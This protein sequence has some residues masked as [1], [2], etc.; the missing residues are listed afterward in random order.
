MADLVE[1]REEIIQNVDVLHRY[2]LGDGPE[3]RFH[4]GR[5]KNG[6]VFAAVRQGDEYRFAPSKFAGYAANNLGHEQKL[7]ERDC[8]VTNQRI[9]SIAGPPLEIGSAAYRAVDDAYLAYCNT[10]GINTP[11]C[12]ASSFLFWLCHNVSDT[13]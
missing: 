11:L 6:K 4:D 8:G 7:A 2:G 5:I 13:P 3:R 10:H 12:L 9:E 1:T